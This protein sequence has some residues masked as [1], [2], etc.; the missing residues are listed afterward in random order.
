MSKL[1]EIKRTAFILLA[2]REHSTL[3]L[4]RKLYRKDFDQPDIDTVLTQLHQENLLNDER[5]TE[6]F[7]HAR[8]AKGYGPLRIRMELTER[9]I[10]QELIEHQLK[11]TD[12]AWF[13]DVR[14][15]WQKRFKN[16]VPQDP[17]S[18]A[19]HMR[20]LQYRGFTSEQINQLFHSDEMKW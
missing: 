13:E 11:I 9:G 8:R 20:F 12:N 14:K 4:S 2:R 5:F 10:S 19:K 18:R 16:S 15:V 17:K 3:E 7:I 6:T 1:S